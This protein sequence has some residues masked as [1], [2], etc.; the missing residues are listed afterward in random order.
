MEGYGIYY[1]YASG[2]KYEVQWENSLQEG[3]GIFYNSGV[4]KH[5]G[6]WLKGI[7]KTPYFNNKQEPT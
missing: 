5:I 7:C 2:S 3:I 4:L 1:H 6:E